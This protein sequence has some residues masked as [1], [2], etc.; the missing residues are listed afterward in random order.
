MAKNNWSEV[1]LRDLVDIKH[2]FAFQGEYFTEEE[3]ENILLTPGNFAIGGGYKGDK[4]KYYFGEVSDEY[5]LSYHD[6]I[7][8]MTDLSKNMDTLGYS[9]LVP[10][11]PGKRF[12]H[13][14]RLGKVLV[15]DEKRIDKYFLFYLLR[16][17]DYRNEVKASA[18]GSVIKHTSPD[19]IR[20][21]KFLLPPL[22]EQRAIAGILGA[23]D[24]KIELNRRMNLTFESMAQAIFHQ[25]FIKLDAIKDWNMGKLG[26]DFDLTM[27]QSPPGDTYNEEGNGLPFFQGRADFG[28]RFPTNRVYC[29]VPTR[30]AEAS[31]TLVSVRAPV[32][33]VNMA[34]EKCAI[35]RGVAAVRHKSQSRSYT[36]YAMKFLRSNLVRFEAEGTVFGAI[37]RAD[38]ENLDVVIPPLDVVMNF[39]EICFP[40]DQKI[41]LNER[42]SRTLTSL[43]DTLLPKLFSGEV[44]I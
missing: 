22:Q 28:F 40:I 6:L 38:F 25:R 37:N 4:I 16:T 8:T 12:L 36:Y 44:S 35:G 21:Y 31:D 34:S 27:G 26:N 3:A 13:N 41:E 1:T 11:E 29:T 9:A 20:N 5:V 18:S 23:L 7:V 43:R 10:D 42:E 14:Q 30:F 32:G 19:R 15:R 17:N 2:G 33:D 24:E 39:E